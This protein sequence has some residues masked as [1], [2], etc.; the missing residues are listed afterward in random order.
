[1]ITH[2]LVRIG[3]SEVKLGTHSFRIGA[4]SM[5]TV[6]G[7]CRITAVPQPV[8]N[9][10][11]VGMIWLTLARSLPLVVAREHRPFSR[12]VAY[13]SGEDIINWPWFCML[14]RTSW[15]FRQN[16]LG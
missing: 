11:V 14:L 9:S 16:G 8:G 15:P 5:A 1:M 7:L 12:Y 13:L 6:M 4:A 3:Q 2:V 10:R